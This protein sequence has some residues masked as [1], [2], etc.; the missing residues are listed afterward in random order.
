M[1]KFTKWLKY[2]LDVEFFCCVLAITM[3]FLYGLELYIYGVKDVKFSI[4]FQMFLW[5]YLVSWFQKLLF[6]KE[7]IYSKKEYRVR[8]I[9]WTAVPIFATWVFGSLLKWFAGYPSWIA[10]CF[11]IILTIYYIFIWLYIQMLY[12]D[13]TDKLNKMLVEFKGRHVSVKN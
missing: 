9:L 6:K 8:S 12:K 1:K 13:E 5:A 2:E 11:Y 7:C 4:I 10:W 3:I